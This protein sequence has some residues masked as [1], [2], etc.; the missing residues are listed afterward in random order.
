MKDSLVD[1]AAL[2]ML[3]LSLAALYYV[4]WLGPRNT[5]LR[6]VMDCMGD[7]RS[8][9]AYER[10]RK[11]REAKHTRACPTLFAGRAPPG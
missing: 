10:C 7:D 3:F 1:L 2:A 9:D 11:E 6:E 5:A 4:F 8:I